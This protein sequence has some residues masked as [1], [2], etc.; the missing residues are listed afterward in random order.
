MYVTVFSPPRGTPQPSPRAPPTL[1]GAGESNGGKLP[2]LN[3]AIL[4]SSSAPSATSPALS[5][6]RPEFTARRPGAKLH[7][8]VAGKGG[9]HRPG[10]RRAHPS[11]RG[12]HQKGGYSSPQPR[13]VQVIHPVQ[14]DGY[15]WYC[16]I[17]REFR[18]HQ[19][20]LYSKLYSY[21]A[22]ISAV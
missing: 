12:V 21:T 3:V 14:V 17:N 13:G 18:I 1:M 2:L 15:L 11:G 22:E 8:V 6:D 20:F 10:G 16:I 7:I 5:T 19:S 9:T 4:Q